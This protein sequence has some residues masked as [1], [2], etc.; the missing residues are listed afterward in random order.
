MKPVAIMEVC[1]GVINDGIAG[2]SMRDGCYSCAPFWEQFPACPAHKKMLNRSLYCK[3]CK[4][5]YAQP[6]D[7]DLKEFKLPSKPSASRT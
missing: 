3:D 4:K 7:L 1:P 5:Y 6:S 2:H